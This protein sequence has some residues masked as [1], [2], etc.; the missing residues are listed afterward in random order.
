MNKRNFIIAV[1]VLVILSAV[2]LWE[3]K[4]LE[5]PPVTETAVSDNFPQ[6]K[7]AES[8]VDLS[9]DDNAQKGIKANPVEGK[10]AEGREEVPPNTGKVS[11]S[12]PL[13]KTVTPSLSPETPKHS[14]PH[15]SVAPATPE[16]SAA[17]SSVAPA[18]GQAAEKQTTCVLSVSCASI[19]K[20]MNKLNPDKRG[21]IPSNGVI[22]ESRTVVFR[23]GDSAF[24]VLQRELKANKIHMEFTNTPGYGS[25]YI[26]G[27]ANI[28]EFDC[29][30]L[31]GWTY[32]V[33][34]ERLGY[35]SSQYILKDGDRV[36][37][38]YSCDL[39]RDIE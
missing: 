36:E 19:L 30:N 4:T 10:D 1:V 16:H 7:Q 15:N 9:E 34:G 25:A 2:F 8:T 32:L 14:V 31:S 17:Q 23:E 37:W 13:P 35:G 11:Q 33:N 28:Y 5:E 38:V 6:E 39:N 12:T 22:L 21:I 27:I 29:G 3:G 18:T 20:N 24:D 26:E